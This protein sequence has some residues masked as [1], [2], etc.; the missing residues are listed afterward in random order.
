MD[1]NL[2]QPTEHTET[3]LH[4]A[5][6]VGIKLSA[7]VRLH[8]LKKKIRDSKRELVSMERAIAK[9]EKELKKL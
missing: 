4:E 6:R 9:M 3:E 8:Y 5:R 1:H 7:K 2:L